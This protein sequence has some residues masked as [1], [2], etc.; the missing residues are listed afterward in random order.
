MANGRY[1]FGTGQIWLAKIQGQEKMVQVVALPIGTETT[2]Q[3]I[4][5]KKAKR[6][7]VKGGEPRVY[8]RPDDFIRR[9]PSKT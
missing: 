7:K 5:R 1:P 8:V 3:A 6:K 2:Y 4:I 9:L